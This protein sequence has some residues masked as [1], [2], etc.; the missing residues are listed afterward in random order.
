[1]YLMGQA[2]FSVKLIQP[3]Q[4][5]SIK[6]VALCTQ[7]DDVLGPIFESYENMEVVVCPEDLM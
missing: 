4:P 3:F 2:F 1:M 6:S 7:Y 5:K